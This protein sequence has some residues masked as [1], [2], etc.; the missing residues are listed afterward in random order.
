MFECYPIPEFLRRG[1]VGLTPSACKD[2]FCSV[3]TGQS[4]AC[5]I[6]HANVDCCKPGMLSHEDKRLANGDVVCLQ[7][8][9]VDRNGERH[10]DLELVLDLRHEFF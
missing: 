5:L 9:H 1:H 7:D 10:V 6:L 8:C 4:R 3:M 2:P